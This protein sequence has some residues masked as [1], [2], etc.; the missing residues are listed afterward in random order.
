MGTFCIGRDLINPGLWMVCTNQYGINF[1]QNR[2]RGMAHV[3]IRQK[4]TCVSVTLDFREN[5]VNIIIS[6]NCC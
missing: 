6:H 5:F 3:R 1:I 4:A 2:A